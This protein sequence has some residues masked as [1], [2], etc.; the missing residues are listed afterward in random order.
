MTLEQKA[1]EI[2]REL[3]GGDKADDYWQ[4]EPIETEWH[5]D[6]QARYGGAL[7]ALRSTDEVV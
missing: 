3:A 6:D 4:L 1:R 7:A 2:A 5:L